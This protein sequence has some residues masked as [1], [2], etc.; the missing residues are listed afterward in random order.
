MIVFLN[1]LFIFVSVVTFNI[2]AWYNYNHTWS[3]FCEEENE[4]EKAGYNNAYYVCNREKNITLNDIEY[5]HFYAYRSAFL[6]D[7]YQEDLLMPGNLTYLD[8]VPSQDDGLVIFAKKV[9]S[10]DDSQGKSYTIVNIYS[11]CDYGLTRSNDLIKIAVITTII[12]AFAEIVMGIILLV[13][14]ILEKA[15]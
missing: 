8:K 14:K 5:V 15:R 4:A 10:Y 3:K 2:F 13:H 12:A 9:S 11:V 1:S 6:D 7:S